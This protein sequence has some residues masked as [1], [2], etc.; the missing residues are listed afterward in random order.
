MEL[1]ASNTDHKWD[2]L[3]GQPSS[4]TL[5]LDL[6]QKNRQKG[7]FKLASFGHSDR[8]LFSHKDTKI[9]GK[10]TFYTASKTKEL[11]HQITQ[12][13]PHDTRRQ[14]QNLMMEGTCLI[15]GGALLDLAYDVVT[16]KDKE[17]G[18][19]PPFAVPDLRFVSACLA[20]EQISSSQPRVFLIEEHID[21]K[22]EGKFR[23]FINNVNPVPLFAFHDDNVADGVNDQTRG[24]FLCFTQHIQYIKTHGLIFVGDYQGGNHSLTDPQL[25]SKGSLGYIFAEGNVPAAFESFPEDHRCNKFCQYYQLTSLKGS[26]TSSVAKTAALAPDV[27]WSHHDVD[28]TKPMSISSTYRH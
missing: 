12:H 24:E 6:S 3:L 11:G 1:S 22:K 16:K 15:W 26:T 4:A 21:S 27:D 10:Q 19:P 14:A 5:H 13:I 28:G 7:A 2:E 23:K 20:I 18:V 17:F 9:C 25:I 8:P